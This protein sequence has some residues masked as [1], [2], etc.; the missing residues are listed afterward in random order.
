MEIFAALLIPIFSALTPSTRRSL[1][2]MSLSITYE[3]LIKL[4][5]LPRAFAETPEEFKAAAAGLAKAIRDENKE[6]IEEVF[7][8]IQGRPA[9]CERLNLSISIAK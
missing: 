3:S 6:A 9:E 2:S 1:M 5:I 7:G 8:P 4:D